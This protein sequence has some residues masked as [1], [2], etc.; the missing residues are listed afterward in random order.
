M[1]FSEKI[2]M[3]IDAS[4]NVISGN[5]NFPDSDFIFD[6]RYSALQTVADGKRNMKSDLSNFG[7]DFKKATNKAK[8]NQKNGKTTSAK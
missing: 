3:F 7:S 1:R 4:A 8:D 6:F 2:K 5:M